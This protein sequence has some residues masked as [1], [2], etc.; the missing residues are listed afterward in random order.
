MNNAGVRPCFS[1]ACLRAG[2]VRLSL[3]LVLALL[4]VPGYVVAPVLFTNLDSHALA[5]H[6]A[7]NIFHIAN[8]GILILLLAVAAF[9][10]KREA[11]RWRWIMLTAVACLVGVNEFLL[12][13]VMESLKLAMGSIDALPPGDPQRAE[14]GMWHGASAILHLLA[15]LASTFLV[16]LGWSGNREG[17][18]KP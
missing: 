8:R 11:G 5:G 4:V 18:C 6:L 2:S 17:H 16:A 15:V 9:W 13:P 3:A 10:W 12:S 14:F 1:L 7:G